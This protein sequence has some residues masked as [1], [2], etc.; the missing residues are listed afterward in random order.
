MSCQIEKHVVTRPAA[1]RRSFLTVAHRTLTAPFPGRANTADGPC[2]FTVESLC[3]RASASSISFRCKDLV[4]RHVVGGTLK[5]WLLSVAFAVEQDHRV[6]KRCTR[7]MLGFN[8][9]RRSSSRVFTFDLLRLRK[10]AVNLQNQKKCLE[11][12]NLCYALLALPLDQGK[13]IKD[14]P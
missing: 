7:P 5:R 8:T 2:V 10:D 12:A 11:S 6:I 4:I 1:L 13:L 9:F 14:L 3:Q